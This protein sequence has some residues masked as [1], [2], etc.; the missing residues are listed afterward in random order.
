MN[1]W[2]VG[3]IPMK[4]DRRQQSVATDI[5][6]L[7]S[8]KSVEREWITRRPRQAARPHHRERRERVLKE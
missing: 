7:S 4:E 5:V 6:A 3:V 2:L 1:E 8:R